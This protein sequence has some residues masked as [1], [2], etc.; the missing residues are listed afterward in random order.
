MDRS[1]RIACS[2]KAA[3]SRAE[4]TDRPRDGWRLI[5]VSPVQLWL[6]EPSDERRE[7]VMGRPRRGLWQVVVRQSG[8]LVA[9]AHTGASLGVAM[10][11]AEGEQG[12]CTTNQGETDG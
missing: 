1:E 7:M 5:D 6:R 2:E 9:R 12:S 4:V 3:R 8:D 11:I 10:E